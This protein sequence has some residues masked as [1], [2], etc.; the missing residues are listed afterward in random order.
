MGS[1][2]ILGFFPT[3]KTLMIKE[4]IAK[5]YDLMAQDVDF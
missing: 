4:A 5:R 1:D 3:G 2:V